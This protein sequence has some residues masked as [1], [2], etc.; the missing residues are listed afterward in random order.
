MS[1][2]ELATLAIGASFRL[3]RFTGVVVRKRYHTVTILLSG[4][5]FR[6][7]RVRLPAWLIVEA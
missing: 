5:L 1:R 7:T 2:V 4:G 6:D 3:G